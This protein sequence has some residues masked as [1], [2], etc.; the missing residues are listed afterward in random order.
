MAF[1]GKEGINWSFDG[2]VVSLLVQAV[3]DVFL[4][5]AQRA[6]VVLVVLPRVQVLLPEPGVL[7]D[8][9]Q[10]VLLQDG[11]VL[12]HRHKHVLRHTRRKKRL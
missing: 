10:R 2:W 6:A 9:L 7:P 11:P 12:K 4:V 1:N 5:D 8:L 3:H